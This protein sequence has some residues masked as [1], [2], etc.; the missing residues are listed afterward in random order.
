MSIT[1]TVSTC[2]YVRSKLLLENKCTKL[3]ANM[4][5][6]VLCMYLAFVI[7]K[8]YSGAIELV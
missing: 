3:G 7:E 6:F 5:C 8:N 2:D 4:S 1:H